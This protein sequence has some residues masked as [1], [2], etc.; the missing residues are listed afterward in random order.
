MKNTVLTAALA[1]ALLCMTSVHAQ[2]D[3][4]EL[5]AAD[6]ARQI[7]AGKLKGED[8]VKALAD[9]IEKKKDQNAFIGYDRERAL[10]AA[11]AA[12]A[13]AAKKEFKGPLHGVPLVVKD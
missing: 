3:L 9:A 5:S 7:R 13:Q 6:A 12:D 11:R 10:K 4:T 2:A 1:S 8:R